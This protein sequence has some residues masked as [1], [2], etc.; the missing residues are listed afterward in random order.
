MAAIPTPIDLTA[1]AHTRAALV[2]LGRIIWSWE[3]GCFADAFSQYRQ[4]LQRLG[5]TVTN[6][7]PARITVAFDNTERLNTPERIAVLVTRVLPALRNLDS[8]DSERHWRTADGVMKGYALL[9]I[10]RCRYLED[11]AL[12]SANEA[13]GEGNDREHDAFVAEADQ[14]RKQA[15]RYEAFVELGVL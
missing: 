3:R 5:R 1:D 6:A 2:L 15:R 10:A 12:T 8:T 11:L 7:E 14:H 4:L 13:D 9:E